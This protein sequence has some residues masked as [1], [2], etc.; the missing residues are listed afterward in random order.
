MTELMRLVVEGVA[1]FYVERGATYCSRCGDYNYD[2]KTLIC[3]TCTYPDHP[4]SRIYLDARDTEPWVDA[5]LWDA[6]AQPS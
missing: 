4:M 5:H 6:A 1:A 2:D 3:L